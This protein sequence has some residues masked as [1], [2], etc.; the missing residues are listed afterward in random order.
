M[1]ASLP[2]LKPRKAFGTFSQHAAQR[3]L[4]TLILAGRYRVA[5]FTAS[6]CT[7]CLHIVIPRTLI[8]GLCHSVVRRLG[9]KLT[10]VFVVELSPSHS[11]GLGF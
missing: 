3:F 6:D 2:A 9:D 7:N 5:S 4:L 8:R 10:A 11:W 1:A